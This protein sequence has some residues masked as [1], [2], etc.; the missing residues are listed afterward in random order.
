MPLAVGAAA[1]EEVAGVLDALWGGPETLIVVSSDLSHYQ[2][3]GRA[4]ELDAA[5][6]AEV[7]ALAVP[8]QHT[9]ACGATPL[10]GLLTAAPRHG[11]RPR[12]VAACNSGDTAGSR[13]RVVGYASVAFAEA[14]E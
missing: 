1:P 13:D 7:L 14:S 8:I 12:L 5:T 11:L 3:Y 10:N 9:Q 4:V 6:I 2:P